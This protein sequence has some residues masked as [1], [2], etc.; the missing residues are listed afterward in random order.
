M[1]LRAHFVEAAAEKVLAGVASQTLAQHR[2]RDPDRGVGR[3]GPDL[4]GGLRFSLGDLGLGGGR[5][6]GHEIGHPL[7]RL[8]RR[9]LRFLAG[10]GHDGLSLSLSLLPA[11]AIIVE[12]L[13]GFLA[14]AASLVEFGLDALAALI[15]SLEQGPAAACVNDD[16]DEDEKGDGDPEFRLFEHGCPQAERVRSSVASTAAR[17]GAWPVSRSTMAVAASAAMPRTLAM[18]SAVRALMA[19]SEAA[20]RSDNSASS[21]L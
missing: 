5:A 13:R 8:L 20:R 12:H 14:Q 16:S 15:E 1:Q 11:A 3:S 19:D 18:A 7:V 10:A 4:G 21:A 17:S 9:A 6:A 2:F